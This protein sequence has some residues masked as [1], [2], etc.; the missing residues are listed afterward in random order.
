[1]LRACFKRVRERV[2]KHKNDQHLADWLRLGYRRLE[3]LLRCEGEV[4]NH[5]RVYRVYKA[6][7][8]TVRKKTRRKRVVQRRSPLTAP[9][10]STWS[11]SSKPQN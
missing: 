3:V 1:M 10:R 4:V 5:K 9:S 6:L 2:L 7:E 8:L 11:V